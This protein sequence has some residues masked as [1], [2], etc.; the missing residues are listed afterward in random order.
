MSH[1]LAILSEGTGATGSPVLALADAFTIFEAQRQVVLRVWEF[2]SAATLGVLGFALGSDQATR[3]GLQK[4]ALQAG[5]SAF[6]LGNG[7]MLYACQR[8]VAEMRPILADMAKA[9]G[10]SGLVQEVTPAGT[11]LAFHAGIAISTLAVIELVH[12]ARLRAKKSE[13]G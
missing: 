6:A 12:R 2:F 3:N 10:A 7:W 13:Q 1:W 5:Y 4:W 9:A 8:D 11:F